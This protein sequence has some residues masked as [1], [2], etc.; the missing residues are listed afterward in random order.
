MEVQ[1]LNKQILEYRKKV[2]E[3]VELLPLE[4]IKEVV[5][6]VEYLKLKETGIKITEELW[7]DYLENYAIT[8][9]PK[10]SKEIEK[11]HRQYLKGEVKDINDVIKKTEKKIGRIQSCSYKE[12]TKGFK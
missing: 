10:L 4:S 5:D 2:I 12:S 8:N 6:F 7:E 3:G 1:K 9:D 11:A